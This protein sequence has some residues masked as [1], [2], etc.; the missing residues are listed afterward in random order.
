MNKILFPLEPGLQSAAAESSG[1]KLALELSTLEVTL[2]NPTT[3]VESRR[4][5]L[6]SA[7]NRDTCSRLY[8]RRILEWQQSL[9]PSHSTR[10]PTM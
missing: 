10:C 5:R 3:K 2:E 1:T 4:L 9:T 7:S 6:S 8:A